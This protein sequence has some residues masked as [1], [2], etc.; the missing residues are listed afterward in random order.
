MR[1]LLVMA[2]LVPLSACAVWPESA[3]DPLG[4]GAALKRCMT[5]PEAERVLHP[6]I[7][8]LGPALAC[9]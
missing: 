1:A 7:G 8:L 4:M 6:A 9:R 2:L 3:D 5:K